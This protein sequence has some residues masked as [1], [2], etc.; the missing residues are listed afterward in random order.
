VFEIHEFTNDNFVAAMATNLFSKDMVRADNHCS[1]LF[2]YLNSADVA[3]ATIVV[4]PQYVDADYLAD[5]SSYYSTCFQPYEKTCKRV[6]FFSIPMTR[7]DFERRIM[8]LAADAEI[9]QLRSSYL[10]FI[11]VRPLPDAVIGRTQLKTYDGGRRNYCA[12]LDYNVHL[13]GVPLRVR[14]LAFQ[15]QD[16]ALAA[17]ATVALWSCFQKTS[18]LFGTSAPR[19]PEI[20]ESATRSFFDRRS[21][22]SEGLYTEQVCSAIKNNDLEPEVFGAAAL[23]TVPLVS[24]IYAHLKM[25]LPVLLMVHVEDVGYHALVVTGYS[26][27]DQLVNAHEIIAA[28]GSTGIPM[29]GRRIDEFYAH[30]DQQGPFSQLRIAGPPNARR[31]PPTFTGPWRTHGPQ[32]RARVLTP[33][34]VIVPVYRKIRL[35]YRHAL[36]WVE[37]VRSLAEAV[38]ASLPVANLEW[39]LFLTTTNDYKRDLALDARLP[40]ARKLHLLTNPQPRFMWRCI[41]GERHGAPLF[42]M[43]IDATG[44]V[45]SFPI[46]TVNFYNNVFAERFKNTV[47]ASTHPIIITQLK[48]LVANEFTARNGPPPKTAAP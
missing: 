7:A 16:R 26:L 29:I 18:D 13:F 6:H 20:T 30:D 4:E 3:A 36:Q 48:A 41:F 43:L 46:E 22:P 2:G 33:H 1:Y 28:D 12:V 39:D 42:E 24:L 19:P 23:E 8:E 14:S 34:S 47:L 44:F 17:C 35:S 27:R 45:K 31:T 11:V 32:P 21:L 15:E 38:A 9:E 37:R 5:Y 10:G 40:E 25:G